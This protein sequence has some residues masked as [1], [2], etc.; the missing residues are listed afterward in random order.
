[1]TF[2][3]RKQISSKYSFGHRNNRSDL[4][5]D[6]FVTGRNTKATHACR[7]SQT[8]G[9]VPGRMKMNLKALLLAAAVTLAPVAMTAQTTPTPSRHNHNIRQRQVNQ[10]RRINQGVKSGQLTRHEARTLM[11]QH[12]AINRET[13]AM[14]AQNNGRLTRQDRKTIHRQQNRESRRIYRK[15]HNARVR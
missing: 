13:R 2:E 6:L 1:M 11:R 5:S 3:A 15:K 8:Q 14:R 12:R 9:E 7:S 4:V 10:Q